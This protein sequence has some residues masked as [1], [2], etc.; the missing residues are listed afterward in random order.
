MVTEHD[1]WLYFAEELGLWAIDYIRSHHATEV[2]TKEGPADFVTASDRAVER[3]VREQVERHHPDHA[4]IGEE[5]GDGGPADA[6]LRWFVD[7]IDGTT[8]YAHGLPWS[9][10]SLGLVDADGPL[11][12]VVADPYRG[13]LFSAIRGGGARLN[14]AP[15]HCSAAT[16]LA[17]SVVATEWAGHRIWDGMIPMFEALSKAECTSRII[18]SSALS[19]ATTAVGRADGC[20]LGGYNTWDVVAGVLIARE[21]GATV[22][23]TDGGELPAVPSAADGGLLVAAPGIANELWR[24]WRGEA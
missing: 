18:G 12:G 7:P 23:G 6:P 14:G 15:V 22:L 4:V 1:D 9:S 17:G 10:F 21:A 24:A 11:V 3:H 16:T 2:C 19:V 20:V 13:E 8:N 5:Y